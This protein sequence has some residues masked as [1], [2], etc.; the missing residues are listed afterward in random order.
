MSQ[1]NNAKFAVSVEPNNEDLQRRFKTV[2]IQRVNGEWTVPC[3]FEDELKT[4]PFLRCHSLEIRSNL[5][6]K[7][8]ASD[9]EV[10]AALRKA[11]D[12]F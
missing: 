1:L 6:M 3:K 7:Q 2:Q 10:F 9:A 11:K 5:G 4:N 8:N 12:N